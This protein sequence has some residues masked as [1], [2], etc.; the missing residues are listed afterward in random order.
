VLSKTCVA[1]TDLDR[2][3]TN[4]HQTILGFDGS[5][6]TAGREIQLWID[7]N[8]RPSTFIITRLKN[9]YDGIL[10]MPWMKTHG[11]RV[12]WRAHVLDTNP[13]AIATTNVVL[14][15]PTT[16]STIGAGPRR[17][18]RMTIGGMCAICALTL[19]QCK[20]AFPI[21]STSPKIAGKQDCLVY[22]R[23]T[24]RSTKDNN[25]QA[26]QEEPAA[27]SRLVSSI[28]KNP[29]N[30]QE[31]WRHAR[32]N[33]KGV[34]ALSTLAL[35]QRKFGTLDPSTHLEMAGKQ[36]PPVILSPHRHQAEPCT[37]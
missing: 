8:K 7:A 2:Y 21:N 19:P 13:L 1:S 37:P 24:A 29:S 16:P 3:A 22:L 30:G 25:H 4:T 15:V 20:L 26:T 12:D 35:L 10:G 34:C 6:S 17:H 23:Q 27:T 31:P 9:T 14:L 18:A 11:H 5:K 36:D 28:P 32:K 33:D